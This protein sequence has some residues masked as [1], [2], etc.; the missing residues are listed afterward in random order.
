MAK[1][2]AELWKGLYHGFWTGSYRGRYLSYYLDGIEMGKQDTY[3]KTLDHKAVI[4]VLDKDL[5][6]EAQNDGY[7]D[8]VSF[9]EEFPNG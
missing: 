9:A 4:D 1:S 8:G 3:A 2:R 7:L 5:E 6:W